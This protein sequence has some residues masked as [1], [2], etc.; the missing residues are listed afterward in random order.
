MR[1][2]VIVYIDGSYPLDGGGLGLILRDGQLRSGRAGMPPWWR[3]EQDYDPQFN[4]P[5]QKLILRG[6]IDLWVK[7]NA[8]ALEKAVT[9]RD[10]YVDVIASHTGKHIVIADHVSLRASQQFRLDTVKHD[11]LCLGV[12]EDMA[13]ALKRALRAVPWAVSKA[14]MVNAAFNKKPGSAAAEQQA[15]SELL[16]C[17]DAEGLKEAQVR[18]VRTLIH[19]LATA[20]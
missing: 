4:P 8:V 5:T 16:R 19:R 1:A 12:S 10:G 11:R 18:K 9:D 2:R 7:A 17:G 20:R 6:S 3:G 15:F 14:R 13:P